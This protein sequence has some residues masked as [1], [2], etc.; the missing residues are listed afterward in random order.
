MDKKNSLNEQSLSKNKLKKVIIPLIILT[1]I[2]SV[3]TIVFSIVHNSYCEKAEAA[4][5]TYDPFGKTHDTS[6]KVGQDPIRDA[7]K[8]DYL[9][10]SDNNHNFGK[11]YGSSHML[12]I[13]TTCVLIISALAYKK[14]TLFTF[15]FARLSLLIIVVYAI[16]SVVN[17]A[18]PD[19]TSSSTTSEEKTVE[20]Y[21]CG[22]K[23][24]I[25]SDNGKSITRNRRCLKCKELKDYLDEL[26]Q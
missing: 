8:Q 11:H 26:P 19:I 21:Y 23:Y 4:Y 5:N 3:L 24:K 7:A 12:A 18:F 22:N 16:I 6:Y 17:I 1:I 25:T 14:N 10:Y 20:C 2:F 15:N 13:A 9:L